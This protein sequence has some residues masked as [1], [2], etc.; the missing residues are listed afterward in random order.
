MILTDV[1]YGEHGSGTNNCL[2]Q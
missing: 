1:I 2:R